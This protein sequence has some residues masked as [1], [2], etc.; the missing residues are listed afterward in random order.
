MRIL[1]MGGLNTEIHMNTKINFL[2]INV[3]G[4]FAPPH[5]NNVL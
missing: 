5:L 2:I 1:Y 4:G 3:L